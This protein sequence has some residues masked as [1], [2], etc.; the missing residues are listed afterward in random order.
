MHISWIGQTCVRLQTKN[1]DEEVVTIIDGYK[2]ATGDFPRSF[3]PQI[4]LY[5][6]GEEN[7]TTLSQSPFIFSSSGECEVKGVMCYSYPCAEGQVFKV[8]AENLNLVHLG[9]ITKKPDEAML[10]KLGTPDILFVPIG[11]GKEY[12]SAQDAA[13]IVTTMEPRIVIPMA[14]QCDT[15]PTASPLSDFIKVLGLTPA[16]TDKKIIIKKKDLPSEEIKLM[17]LEKNY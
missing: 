8:N 17:V 5:S 6:H 3:S 13:D 12:L 7:T 15:D 4:S 14:Y 1:Q 10:E 16:V 9:K 11:G 2:P